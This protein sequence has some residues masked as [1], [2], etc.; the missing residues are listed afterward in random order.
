[1]RILFAEDERDLNHIITKKLTGFKPYYYKKA[2][3]TRIQRR[4]RI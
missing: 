3:V 1:M 4:Q 2:D